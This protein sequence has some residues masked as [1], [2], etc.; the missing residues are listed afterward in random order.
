MSYPSSLKLR[1]NTHDIVNVEIIGNPFASLFE[2]IMQ[3]HYVQRVHSIDDSGA[4]WSWTENTVVM[5]LLTDGLQLIHAPGILRVTAPGV[6]HHLQTKIHSR[7][8]MENRTA[9][10]TKIIP[11]C[12]LRIDH[13]KVTHSHWKI[14]WYAW[15]QS[16]LG[17]NWVIMRIG[18]TLTHFV[19]LLLLNSKAS[20]IGVCW[21]SQTH[22]MINGHDNE[23]K[24][25]PTPT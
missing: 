15:I 6:L 21:V 19:T 10:W 22:Q 20:S 3:A 13:L 23:M 2:L 14:Q 18:P 1:R 8:R 9:D 12:Q 17:R 5:S 24:L 11:F 7:I 16:I 25:T 4:K